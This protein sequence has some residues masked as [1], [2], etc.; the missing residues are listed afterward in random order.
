MLRL[1]EGEFRCI[2]SFGEETHVEVRGV[3]WKI[4]LK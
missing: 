4:T 1:R 2:Q 3:D